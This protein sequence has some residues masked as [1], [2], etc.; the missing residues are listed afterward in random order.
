VPIPTIFE[1]EGEEGFRRREAALID[2]LT[3]RTGLVLATGGG[4][5]LRHENRRALHERGQRHLP[6]GLTCRTVGAAAARSPATPLRTAQPRQRIAELLA[7]REPLY[8]QT[9]HQIVPTGRQ[10]VD[11]V[12]ADIIGRMPDDARRPD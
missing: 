4:A 6:Q 2:E 9:A 11:A 7:F 1:L 3:R 5:V 12:V 8:E 10:S